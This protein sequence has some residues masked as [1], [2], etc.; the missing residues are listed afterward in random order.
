MIRSSYEEGRRA[1]SLCDYSPLF[2]IQYTDEEGALYFVVRIMLGGRPF[3]RF[4]SQ[5]ERVGGSTDGCARL[6]RRYV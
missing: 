3:D 5:R 6:E 1:A 2:F 4:L